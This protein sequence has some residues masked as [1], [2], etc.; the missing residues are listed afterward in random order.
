MGNN[1]YIEDPNSLYGCF[2]CGKIMG[3]IEQDELTTYYKCMECGEIGVVSF[4]Q[5]LDI[6]NDMYRRG[7]IHLSNELDDLDII[8]GEEDE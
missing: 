7:H 2:R 4:Q 3:E 1:F 5:G 8:L 6:I